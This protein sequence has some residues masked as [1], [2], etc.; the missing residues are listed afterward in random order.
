MRISDWISD[1][2]SSDLTGVRMAVAVPTCTQRRSP[3]HRGIRAAALCGES[4]DR[5]T[6]AR[7]VFAAALAAVGSVEG[8]GDAAGDRLHHERLRA[9]VVL[10]ACGHETCRNIDGAGDATESEGHS[11]RAVGLL[12]SCVSA[13][14]FSTRSSTTA[15]FFTRL[16]APTKT[17]EP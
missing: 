2:C 13:C 12:Q 16:D 14:C 5:H 7:T 4:D 6:L 10:G 11:D 8:V 15:H 3:I 9:D 17:P 1:V